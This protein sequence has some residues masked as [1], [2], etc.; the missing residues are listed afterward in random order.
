MNYHDWNRLEP[1][2]NPVD[3]Y[4]KLSLDVLQA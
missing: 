3:S 2:V 4:L 1:S